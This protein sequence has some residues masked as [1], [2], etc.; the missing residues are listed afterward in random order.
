MWRKERTIMEN[1][2]EWHTDPERLAQSVAFPPDLHPAIQTS[3]NQKG[4]QSLYTHQAESW[5][6]IRAG[7]NV[8]I[9]TG[10]ASGKTLCYQ[11]P[12]LQTYLDQPAATALFFFPTK[13]LTQDQFTSLS[14]LIRSVKSSPELTGFLDNTEIPVAI[15]DGDTASSM[16]SAIRSDAHMLLTNP[17]MLHIGILPHHTLWANFFR[18]LRFIVIDE[19][20]VYRGVF[21]SHIA[22]VI[23]RLKRVAAFYGASPQF[24]LTSATIANPSELAERLIEEPVAEIDRDGS[25]RGE[26]HFL[27]YN[28]PIIQPEMGIRRPSSSESV[29][30]TTDLLAYHVQT[31]MFTRTR[32]SVELLLKYLQDQN[33]D[34]TDQLHGYRSGYLPQERRAIERD[35]REGVTRAVVTTNA[36]ELGVDIGT[37]G[38][39]VMVGYPGTI[40]A[41]R[42][43]SGRA[44]RRTDSSLAVLVASA[45]PLDQFLMTHPEY[46]FGRSPE[47]ALINPDNLL[48]LL[49]HIRCAAFELPFHQGD[50]FGRFPVD[51]LSELL[52]LLSQSGLLHLTGNNY[53]WVADQYPANDISLRSASGERILLSV[54]EDG[55][56]HTIGEVDQESAH[57]M[58]H[59]QAIYLHEGRSYQVD[60]LSFENKRATLTPADVDYFT[61]PRS[62]VNIEKINVINQDDSAGCVRAVGEVLV[63]SQVIGFRRVSWMTREVLSEHTLEM[64]ATQLRTIGYWLALTEATVQKIRDQG[65][66]SNDPNQ[67]GPGWQKIKDLVRMRDRYTCQVCGA[68]ESGKAFHVHHIVPFKQFISPQQANQ[69]TNLITLC[70]AC[71]QRAETSVYIRSGL[72]GL[73]YVLHQMAPLFLMCDIGD[74]G[75]HSDPQSPIG[76][77]QPTVIIYDMLPAG[78]GLSEALYQGH[79]DLLKKSF[80]LVRTC[81]CRDGCPGCVGPTA[82]NG[83][84]G[85][86]ETLAILSLLNDQFDT[87]FLLQP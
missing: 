47:R 15:Y 82:V 48:I 24:I 79:T 86:Q 54:D 42:Q 26:K 23:R 14:G 10:T 7:K 16:R 57:W 18:N 68:P 63:T 2:V 4:I 55:Q 58:V 65:L 87:Q 12:I 46:I 76:D 35:L 27:L 36:L 29:R 5:E 67:Y 64:P 13:A 28:P 41:T 62:D 21:G 40:A 45:G 60:E 61:E 71:H 66:W 69:I 83:Y 81:G 44:G 38:A 37:A 3:L 70:P 77:L 33:Y 1:V 50:S 43:Q 56:A 39:V 22:N 85:K 30:L 20:H 73:S 6:S 53:Y 11:L 17:D 80:D 72:A 49:Q 51:Q 32:R 52:D 74:L 59:P 19:I 78:V 25:P 31:L 34:A 9:V 75:V 84:G 8:V